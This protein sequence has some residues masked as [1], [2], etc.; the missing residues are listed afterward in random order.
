[1]ADASPV[2]R[3]ETQ[4][5]PSAQSAQSMKRLGRGSV[6]NLG[7]VLLS[8]VANFG[9]VVVLTRGLEQTEAGVFFSCTS[10]FLL[11]VS[12]G[13]LGTSTGLVYFLSR[14]RTLGEHQLLRPYLRAAT[15]PVIV[16]AALSGIAV[17]V[18][19]PQ[20]AGWSNP[21]HVQTATGYLRVLAVFIPFASIKTLNLSAS[22]GM[23]TMRAT[24][25]VEQIGRPVGQL[26]LVGTVVLLQATTL[27]PYAWAV[28]FILGAAGGRKLLGARLAGA[29][30]A[31]ARPRPVGREFWT[32]T[33]P[34]AIANVAQIA[35]QRF[36][37][38]LVG[39]LAGAGPAAIYTASTRFLV[40][41]QMGNRAVSM[42]A[43]PR[44]AE[45]LTRGVKSDVNH[46]YRSST[47]WLMIAT[48]PVYLMFATV[49]GPLLAV[50]GKDYTGGRPLLALLSGA[51]LLAT[52]CGM[53]DI[54]LNMAGKSSWNL[55]NV[56]SAF[57]VNLTLDLILIP[58]IGIMGAAIGWAAA[59]I[60]QN[61][62]S[63]T[64]I[65]LKEG[66]H[67]FGR[68]TLVVALMALLS[69]GAIPLA[70]QHFIGYGV[71]TVLVSG[72]AG[73]VLY[74]VLLFFARD[75]LQLKAL[76]Q[77]RRKGRGGRGRQTPDDVT[78]TEI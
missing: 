2:A 48:W 10:L 28:V 22:R 15:R 39:A 21:Q 59:I 26:L 5:G 51:M 30:Q 61:L 20:I 35:M 13:Q 25:M 69:F 32:F 24:V 76:L 56:L 44:L 7:G 1:M 77:V 4:A 58:K 43:Q 34:R 6:A 71:L 8:A 67:P 31:T 18:F 74:A 68:S 41:G 60:T 23:G 57:A 19:A 65:G 38:V 53:V 46:I 9:V 12:V 45:A 36:D 37:I 27:L 72:T 11:A 70:V 47:A 33:G 73:C 78:P 17:F 16:A 14:A 75:L 52:G 40:L 29:G 62:L 49:G 64:Q 3:R 50:F 63:V 42:S 55:I 54:V 66:L